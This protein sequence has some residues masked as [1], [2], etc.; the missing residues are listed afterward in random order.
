MST[1]DALNAYKLDS[2]P[3]TLNSVVRGLQ[4]T[5]NYALSSV[6]GLGDPGLTAKAKLVAAEAVKTYDPEYG[7]SLETHVSNNLKKLS[8]IARAHKSP[9]Q[10]PER[11]QLDLYALHRSETEYTDKYGQEPDVTQ[12]ADYSGIP[13]KRIKK[14]RLSS[15]AVPSEEAGIE[16]EEVPN[17]YEEALDYVYQESDYRDRKIMEHKL[18]YGGAKK[19]AGNE[20]AMK[21]NIDPAQIT[22]RSAKLAMKVSELQEALES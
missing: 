19:M 4:P 8:R 7:A 3:D 21:L 11:T 12:L 1:N 10:L 17:Y 18:G 9:I 13:I 5:I 22:R 14:L 2:T 16:G 15:L 20:I 6:S